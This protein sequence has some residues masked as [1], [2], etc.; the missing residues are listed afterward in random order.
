MTLP[1]VLHSFLVYAISII[2]S[3]LLIQSSGYRISPVTERSDYQLVSILSDRTNPSCSRV[4]SMLEMAGAGI[5]VL[6]SIASG[7]IGLLVMN[8]RIL[9]AKRL[10]ISA[11]LRLESKTTPV[12]SCSSNRKMTCCCVWYCFMRDLLLACRCSV[13]RGRGLFCGCRRLHRGTLLCSG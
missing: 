13:S 4:L 12:L 1:I 2:S 6:Y 5:A 3:H 11:F 10:I 8:C 7:V 9:Q